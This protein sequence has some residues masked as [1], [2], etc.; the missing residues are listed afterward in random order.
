[1]I[2]LRIHQPDSPLPYLR[3]VAMHRLVP[4]MLIELG[5]LKE[6]LARVGGAVAFS[7]PDPYRP[8]QVDLP[9]YIGFTTPANAGEVEHWHADQAEAYLVVAGEA[10][11]W[12]KHRWDDD[13]W[14]VRR[15]GAGS[16]VVVQPGVCHLFRWASADGLAVVFKNQRPGVGRFPAGKT[17]CEAGCPHYNRGCVRPADLT[18]EARKA[19]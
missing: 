12:G 19:A 15:A 6:D 8:E 17:T 11:V 7:V 9:L 4:L 1:M 2:P 14:V 18:G 5:G 13:G 3:D 16:L 10:E